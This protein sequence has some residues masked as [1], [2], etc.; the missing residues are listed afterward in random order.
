MPGSR[1]FGRSN[2]RAREQSNCYVIEGTT[3]FETVDG[4]FANKVLTVWFSHLTK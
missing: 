1:M 2:G 4:V 3:K